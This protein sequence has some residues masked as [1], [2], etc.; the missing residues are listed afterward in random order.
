MYDDV[1]MTSTFD[2]DLATFAPV[3]LDAASS[4]IRCDEQGEFLLGGKGVE[5]NNWNETPG[6]IYTL[7]TSF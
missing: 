2:A 5:R 4:D 7:V 1:T 6:V 3:D